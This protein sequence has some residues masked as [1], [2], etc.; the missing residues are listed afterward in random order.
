[1]INDIL[2][3]GSIHFISVHQPADGLRTWLADFFSA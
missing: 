1:M 2:K 3:Q